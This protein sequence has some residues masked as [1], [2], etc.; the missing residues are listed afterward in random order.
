MLIYNDAISC[1]GSR[2]HCLADL[3]EETKENF[4]SSKCMISE[5]LDIELLHQIGF[6]EGITLRISFVLATGIMYL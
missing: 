4:E 1:L 5:K 3:C 6:S 2:K